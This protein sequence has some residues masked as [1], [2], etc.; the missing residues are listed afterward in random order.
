MVQRC[1]GTTAELGY[2]EVKLK[3]ICP[4]KSPTRHQT[5]LLRHVYSYSTEAGPAI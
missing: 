3:V 4:C 1:N 5:V 2:L